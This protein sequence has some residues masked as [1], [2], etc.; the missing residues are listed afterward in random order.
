MS[1]NAKHI[2]TFM[3]GALAGLAAAKYMSMTEEEKEK[4]TADLKDKAGKLKEEAE[5][6][7][8][9]TKDYFEEL[10]TKGAEAFKEHWADAEQTMN[11]LFGNKKAENSSTPGV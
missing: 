3:M 2:A 5:E 10:K 4:M 8:E 9:K 6:A 11:D 7:F 1:V